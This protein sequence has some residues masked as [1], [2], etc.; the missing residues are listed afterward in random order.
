MLAAQAPAPWQGRGVAAAVQGDIADQTQTA[1]AQAVAMIG[2]TVS[3]MRRSVDFYTGVLDFTKETDDELAGESV[4]ELLG[5]FGSRI[6]VVRL[7]L[8]EERLQLTE[9]LA[10]RGRPTPG[11]T[12]A[13][14]ST[15]PSS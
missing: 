4:E 5:V 14:S 3:D 12:T 11:A 15:S 10:P 1:A 6:R 13:G 9:Y 2:L 8:G 7:R